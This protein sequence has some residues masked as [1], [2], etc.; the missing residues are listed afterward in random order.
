MTRVNSGDGALNAELKTLA[1][2]LNLQSGKRQTL[3]IG[4]QRLRSEF[5]QETAQQAVRVLH[6]HCAVLPNSIQ[7]LEVSGRIALVQVNIM[8]AEAGRER[9]AKHI[10]SADIAEQG[11]HC[12]ERV[13]PVARNPAAVLPLDEDL[14]QQVRQPVEYN[15]QAALRFLVQNRAA[16]IVERAGLGV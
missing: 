8:H 15:E 2:R 4:V 7:A 11:F 12:V 16:H 9:G 6:N 10:N 13:F 14:V 5:R 1:H 3:I